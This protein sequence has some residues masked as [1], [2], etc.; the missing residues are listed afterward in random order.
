MQDLSHIE[1][2]IWP[3]TAEDTDNHIRP[4]PAQGILRDARWW[5]AK[6]REGVVCFTRVKFA[7]EF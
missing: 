4:A 7:V 3:Q 1:A 6:S 2:R 5:L